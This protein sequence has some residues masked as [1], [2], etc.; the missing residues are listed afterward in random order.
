MSRTRRFSICVMSVALYF[1]LLAFSSSLQ[2]QSFDHQSYPKL[3]F[4][5]QSLEL[6]LGLQPQNLRIDGAAKYQIEAN[7]SGADTL[8]LYASRLDISGVSVN[9]ESADFSL[10]NDSLF[11][12]VDD[13]TEA[14]QQYTVNIRYSGSPKFGLLKN[15]NGTIWT[16]QLPKT[17][18]HWVPIVDHP[19]VELKTTFNISVPSGFQIWAT[20][21]KSAEEAVSVDVMRYQFASKDEVPASSLAFTVG[22]FR[23][24][25]ATANSKKLNLAVER[26]LADSVD[27]QTMLQSANDYV[28]ALEERLGIGY[29]HKSLN[30]VVLGDHTWETKS[31]G[32]STVF[33]YKNRGNLQVQLLRSIVG[34]WFGIYQREQQWD[35]AD[36]ITLYQTLLT[37]EILNSDTKLKQADIPELNFSTVYDHF[38]VERWNSW[39]SGLENWQHASVR[40]V[41]SESA[42]EVLNQQASVISWKDYAQ[43]WYQ[44]MGQPLF[45]MPQFP[46]RDG[47]QSQQQSSDS[48]TYKVSYSLDEAEG[49]LT[50]RFEATEGSYSELT[51]LK[52]H[53]VYPQNTE[54]TEVTFTG[55]DDSVVLQV[56][57]LINTLRL[58]TEGHPKLVLDEYKPAPFL[59]Y[60][61]RNG[62]TVE[63]RASAARKL[64]THTD[65]PDLQLAIQDFMNQELKP[66][67]RAALLHSF[68]DIT[69]GAAGT[70]Q[71]F[72]DA[73]ESENVAV[74]NAGLSGLQYYKN[75]SNVRNRVVSA[76]WSAETMDFFKK[77]TQVLTVIASK[78]EFAKF[79]ESVTQRDSVGHESV[80][81]I[82][83]LANMGSIQEAISKAD[84]FTGS[85]YSYDVRQRALNILIQHDHTPSDWLSR[86]EKLL[87]DA[88]PRIRFLTIRGLERN[89]NKEI[90]TFLN[91]YIQDEYDVRV[92]NRIKQVI[93]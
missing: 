85:K 66:E 54:S 93:E 83:E 59:I 39:Q 35:Q 41:I 25:S 49:Q 63:Q 38:G 1:F 12:L 71:V 51:T 7:V 3:D 15:K 13:S 82:Q 23:S 84:L 69:Q 47:K 10:S 30:I 34:Q 79:A 88:D 16:S 33:L 9:E 2:A 55:S 76:A 90:M 91:R 37:N 50:L 29:P 11:V 68:G 18:R 4:D 43:F 6:D 8:T 92:H 87:A 81:V 77:A 27:Q 60:E 70:Q 28:S 56:D 53:E 48:V 20:G 65:N 64:G 57:P 40:S 21:Q 78:E 86:A 80:F 75:D 14:G 72:F 58:E 62:E 5:F 44:R 73:L 22:E 46:V 74:R 89:K 52:V 42:S 61:L 19:L 45:D 36:A 32:A 24:W 26:P 17:Q 31:W 67:T